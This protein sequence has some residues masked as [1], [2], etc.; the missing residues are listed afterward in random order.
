MIATKRRAFKLMNIDKIRE[1][2]CFVLLPQKLQTKDNINEYI[3][4]V[5]QYLQSIIENAIPWAK[6]NMEAKPFWNKKCDEITKAIQAFRQ[7][8]SHTRDKDSW[9]AY[10]CSNNKKQ[11]IIKKAKTFF[12]CIQISKAASSPK[13]M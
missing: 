1:L 4:K 12:F 13:E 6:P 2:K 7:E 10:M 11:K 5:Q 3:T 8:W 9:R